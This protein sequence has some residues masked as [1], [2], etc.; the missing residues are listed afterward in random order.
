MSGEKA[1]AMKAQGPS[2]RLMRR[3]VRQK[4]RTKVGPR[5]FIVFIVTAVA[6]GA[7]AIS[8][9]LTLEDWEKTHHSD[10]HDDE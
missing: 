4:V 8:M 1:S 6:L 10:H 5:V 3:R 9:N 7:I 2:A